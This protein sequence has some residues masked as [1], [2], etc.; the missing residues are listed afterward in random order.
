MIKEN[1]KVYLAGD[2][3]GTKTLLAL[4]EE[5]AGKI[6]FRRREIYTSPEYREFEEV[7]VRFLETTGFRPEG[8]EACFGVAGPVA[9]RRCKTLNLP[10]LVDAPALESRFGFR[11]VALMNDF[12]SI[13]H[14]I[15]SLEP[16]DLSVLQPGKRVEGGRTIA[17]LG[18]GTGLGEAGA[19]YDPEEGRWRVIPTEGGHADFA[20]RN[21][22][23]IELLRFLRE[24]FDHVSYE[25]I[26]SGAG[27]VHL[28]DFV[29]ASGRYEV[30]PALREAMSREDPAAVITRAALEGGDPLCLH[31]L[32]LFISVYGAEAGNLALKYLTRGGIYLAGGIAPR[33][34]E[35]LLDGTFLSAFTAKGRY[36][37]LMEEIPVS[38]ILNPE[39]G[40]LGAAA[41]AV[42][43]E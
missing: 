14:G 39:V 13:V 20:P 21:E 27:L 5:V 4:A 26:L 31:I 43:L 1:E 30:S 8:T 35:K 15:P 9:G 23:E 7:L 2:I 10:W 29:D 34:R 22:E 38:M 36:R 6:V 19:L 17:V 24:R 37:G 18:A 32:D 42:G 25:R 3:G 33:I 40:L 41:V 16:E 11:Q 12:E 28:F